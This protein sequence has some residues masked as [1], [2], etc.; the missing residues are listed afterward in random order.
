ML[1]ELNQFLLAID[2]METIPATASPETSIAEVKDLVRRNKL[3]YL[4][5][6]SQDGK[7]EGFLEARA[8]EKLISQKLV[9]LQRKSESLG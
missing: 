6:V 5:I 1:S 3:E 9:E 7:L 8:I 2:V 4:P